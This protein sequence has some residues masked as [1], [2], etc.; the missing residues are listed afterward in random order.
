MN[1]K[2]KLLLILE[3]LFAG[4]YI[5]L[6]RGLLFVYLVSIGAGIEGIS[7]VV[8]ISAFITTIV[9][10]LL[11][12]NPK[13]LTTKIWLKFVIFHGLERI[14]FI[15][16]PFIKNYF[17]ISIIFGAINSL[18]IGAF[19]NLII[20]GSFSEEDIKDVTAKRTASLN[21]SSIIGF[22][23]AMILVA[24]VPSTMKFIYIYLIGSMIGLLC[25]FIVALMRVSHLEGMTIPKGVEQPE[26][27]FSTSFYFTITLASGNLLAMVWVPY[28][29]DYLKAPDYLA[30]AMSLAGTFSSIIASLFWKGLSLKT[31]RNSIGLDIIAPILASITPFPIVHPILFAFS[32]FTYTGSNFIGNFLFARYNRWL[33]AIKSSI[34]LIIILSLAQIIIAPISIILKGSYFLIF[35]TVI[36]LKLMAFLL[37]LI[38]IPEIAVLPEQ[39]ARTYSFLL[40]NNSLTGY[41]VSVELSKETILLTLRLIV[42]SLV[43]LILYIIYRILFLIIF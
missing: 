36:G 30:V 27:L 8:G 3:A 31:L 21:V 5:A 16:I 2:L 23:L 19:I 9:H 41:R 22:I 20:Y 42:F 14:L 1:N 13:F 10:L 6:T 33:G 25:T 17:L 38:T 24:F 43:L 28:V 29:M 39:T 18:P 35:L 34:L 11:Y 4:A 7:I 37:A 32:S 15:F 40:Y 26:K 12:K